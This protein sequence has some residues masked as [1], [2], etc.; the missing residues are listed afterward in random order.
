MSDIATAHS[1]DEIP[2][3][4]LC[5][6][7]SHPDRLA[8]I[9]TLLGMNPAPVSRCRVLELGCAGGGNLLPM[10]YALP[11]SR[12]V[13]VD[14]SPRQIEEANAIVETLQLKNIRF[15]AMNILDI[16][17]DFGEFDYI[18]AHGVYSWVP[19]EVRDK[20]LQICKQNLAPQGIAYVSYNTYPGWHSFGM[21]REMMLYHIRHIQD[22]QERATQA[23]ELIYFIMEST[24]EDAWNGYGP[25]IHSYAE[26]LKKQMEHAGLR[27]DSALLHDELEETNDPVYFYQF[28]EHAA[29]HGL[30]YLAESEFPLVMPGNFP[31]PVFERLLQM[32]R[33]PLEMEQY[34]DFL[35]NRPFRQTLLCHEQSAINRQLNPGYVTRLYAATVAQAVV[36]DLDQPTIQKI[37]GPDGATFATDHAVTKAALLHLVEMSPRAVSFNAL[38]TEARKRLGIERITP[39]DAEI[40]A[41]NLLQAF[42]YSLRLME[43]HTYAPAF[44]MDISKRPVASPLARLQAQSFPKV[45]NLRHERVDLDGLSQYVLRYLNGSNDRKAIFNSVV[46]KV[47]DGSIRIHQS[48]TVADNA[49]SAR[50]VLERE[51]EPTLHWLA[52]AALLID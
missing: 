4:S 22:P 21:A 8:T 25:F 38:L 28:A 45:T 39:D 48:G 3:P 50:E 27:K 41:T 43:L 35:R 52:R 44:V 26:L 7:Q 6:S 12:F 15:E 29:Q 30:K 34:M 36:P 24:P 13:G 2:Y 42:T 37:V 10:A 31:R 47:E 17:A 23:R 18:I 11:E 9:A 1:Y 33:T 5:Y 51:L 40:L 49:D 20:V 32:A 16:G 14:Y 19:P 46:K